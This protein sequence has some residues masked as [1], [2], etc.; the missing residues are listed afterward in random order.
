MYFKLKLEIV[1]LMLVDSKS[2][3]HSMVIKGEAWIVY[4]GRLLDA[5]VHV[6]CYQSCG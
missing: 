2:F 5:Q 1:L 3:V 4:L 6:C